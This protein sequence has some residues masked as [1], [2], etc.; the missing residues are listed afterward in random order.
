MNSEW[1]KVTTK[2][3]EYGIKVLL[4]HMNVRAVWY[5]CRGSTDSRGEVWLIEGQIEIVIGIVV[6]LYFWKLWS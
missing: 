1:I 6:L 3:P 5:G 2:L 4:V